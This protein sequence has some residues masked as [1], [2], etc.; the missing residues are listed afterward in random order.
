MSINKLSSLILFLTVLG[1]IIFY[2]Y[3]DSKGTNHVLQLNGYTNIQITGHR[4]SG[5]GGSADPI[6]T[7]FK[8]VNSIGKIV[9][10]IVCD[11]YITHSI[12]L[13]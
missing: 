5:C 7:E 1:C 8:A 10:G 12:K 9:T 2:P 6:I 11:E 4:Y 3:T 13:D